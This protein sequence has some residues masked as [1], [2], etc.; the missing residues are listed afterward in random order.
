[1]TA[2]WLCCSG[3]VPSTSVTATCNHN[4]F[5]ETFLV[6]NGQTVVLIVVTLEVFVH[7]GGDLPDEA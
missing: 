6:R 5:D 4:L 1:M 2:G 3:S 7:A